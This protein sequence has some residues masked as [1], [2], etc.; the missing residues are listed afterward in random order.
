MVDAN[1]KIISELK[2]F[3]KIVL[4]DSDFRKVAFR[5]VSDFTRNRKLGFI[6]IVGF[7][8]NLPKRSLS[9]ELEDFFELFDEGNE[10]ATKGAFSLQRT[11]LNHKFFLIWNQ[12][13]IECFYYFYGENVKRWRGF[14]L[15][16]VDGSTAYL[17]DKPEVVK[18]FGTQDNQV[19]SVPMARIL[20]IYDILNDLTVWGDIRPIRESEQGIFME[21]IPYLHKDS[22]VVFDRA[23]PSF[24]L[25]YLMINQE[26]P[27][28]FVSRCK[29]QFNKQVSDFLCSG[30]ESMVT[31]WFANSEA[32]KSLYKLGYV[33]TKQTSIKIR[34]VRVTLISGETEVLL[35]NLY[36]EK[37]YTIQDLYNLYGLRWNIETSYG[38]Q[39]NQ[40]QMEQFSGHRVICIQ[41]DYAAGLVSAN[42][43]S[44][45]EKQCESYLKEINTRRKYKAKINRNI[46][47]AALKTN[48]VRLIFEMDIKTILKKLE[49]KFQK[50]LELIR[51]G[52]K[53]KRR[54]KQKRRRGKYQ[55]LTNYLTFPE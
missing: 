34:M 22:L 29:L 25:F 1:L 50:N 28:H 39:K 45:V 42:L 40:Q 32:I 5:S 16:A 55:T 6:R 51:P 23:Y 4:V 36:D 24:H 43:R 18:Y 37:M 41:Q 53:S 35:T 47:W 31:E 49:K 7:I 3:L 20:Q 15:Y 54:Y 14:K 21:R 19:S 48:I 44:L 2:Y 8:M 30:K 17:V 52:R 12:W 46:S 26:S 13:L 11:K 10:T 9:V 33:I 27:L 38:Y